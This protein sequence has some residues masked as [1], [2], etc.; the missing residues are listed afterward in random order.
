MKTTNYNVNAT[1]MNSINTILFNYKKVVA[2]P[3]S[4]HDSHII[5]CYDMYYELP[6]GKLLYLEPIFLNKEYSLKELC[7]VLNR[8]IKRELNKLVEWNDDITYTALYRN[9]HSVVDAYKLYKLS[10]EPAE[11]MKWD[12][13]TVIPVF[14]ATDF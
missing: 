10:E 14:G 13:V 9:R 6:K 1:T 12:T 2:Q 11:F 3:F 7:D 5:F 8:A 4:E